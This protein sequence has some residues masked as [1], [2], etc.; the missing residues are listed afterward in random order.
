[1]SSREVTISAE[2]SSSGESEDREKMQGGPIDIEQYDYVKGAQMRMKNAIAEERGELEMNRYIEKQ[3]SAQTIKIIGDPDK[4]NT[5]Y[6]EML[7]GAT[8][9]TLEDMERYEDMY[10]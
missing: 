8:H 9:E 6:R 4:L 1:M 2:E 10:F 7:S 5:I 3:R